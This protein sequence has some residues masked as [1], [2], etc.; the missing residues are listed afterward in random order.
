MKVLV[1]TDFSEPA[2]HAVQQALRLGQ[3]IGGE[4]V[5]VHV[6][7]EAPRHGEGLMTTQEM[8][9]AHAAARKWATETL[10]ARAAAA[11][12]HGLAARWLLTTGV[13]AREIARI[14]T[15]EGADYVVIG[16]RGRGGLERAFL[17]SVADR[18]VRTAPC[19]VVTVRQPASRG[20]RP[21]S[22]IFED[23]SAQP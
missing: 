22:A 7:D 11:R 2:E 5:F 1:P 13:P 6:M 21:G 23:T 4:V 18:V 10:E 3:A 19:P 8:R 14:A 12:D 15:E 9:D 17:G 20:P 16:T